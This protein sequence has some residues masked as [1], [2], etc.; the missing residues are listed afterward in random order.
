[1]LASRVG[2]AARILPSEMLVEFRG[3][4]DPDYP[5]RL[6]DRLI[7]LL[8]AETDFSHRP[9]C[10]ALARTHF[11]YN[12]LALRVAAVIREALAHR[13]GLPK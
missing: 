8:D 6:A 1:V 5:D 2:E 3:N 13:R 9:E 11:D 12:L 10:V 4:S 7:R